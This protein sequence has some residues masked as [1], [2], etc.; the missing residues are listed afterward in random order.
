MVE[1]TFAWL[2]RNRRLAKDY[3]E[4]PRVSEAWV[5]LGMLRLLVKRLARAA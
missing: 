4:N 3:E 1:R 2:G 5:Y